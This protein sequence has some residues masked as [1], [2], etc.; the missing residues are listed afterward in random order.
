MTAECPYCHQELPPAYA[1][2]CLH[3]DH[4]LPHNTP[5]TQRYCS[6]ACRDA[7][8]AILNTITTPYDFGKY[9]QEPHGEHDYD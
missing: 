8:D 7:L 3:C 1:R 5:P 4:P 9:C 2:L 6:D